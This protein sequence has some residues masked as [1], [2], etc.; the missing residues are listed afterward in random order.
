VSD[1]FK[2]SAKH[3]SYIQMGTGSM[4]LNTPISN[5]DTQFGMF[6]FQTSAMQQV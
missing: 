3:A 6:L 5:Q 2:D 1:N 4:P